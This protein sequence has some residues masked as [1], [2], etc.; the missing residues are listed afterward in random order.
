M[1]NISKLLTVVIPCYNSSKTI[2]RTLQSLL[3]Q[4]NKSFDV[5]VVD[6]FSSDFLLLKNIIDDF[7]DK[8]DI[9][10]IR[11][12][13]NRNGA[14]ARNTGIAS[15]KG[16]YICFL[17]SDDTWLPCKVS[18]VVELIS[19]G[20][21]K[22][23]T[24]FYSSLY[25]GT[26]SQSYS[27][28]RVYPKRGVLLNEPVSEYIF[29]HGGLIQ[30][31]T[32]VCSRELAKATMFNES[33][34]RHQDYDFVIRCAINAGSILF[35]PQPLTKWNVESNREVSKGESADFCD[36]W[37]NEMNDYLSD[38]ARNAYLFFTKSTRLRS[39]GHLFRCFALR[40]TIFISSS[41]YFKKVVVSRFLHKVSGFLGFSL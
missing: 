3:E 10:L 36:Y 24:L 23:D 11:H 39:S 21:I 13:Y 31:S 28:C 16:K 26:E 30:T 19:H 35:Y 15:A 8:L 7:S 37:L 29:L 34:K 20:K 27:E 22:E 18:K 33:F 25:L 40:A 41:M 9:K 32:L 12:G 6:D 2:S 1:E 17:D 14:A 4:S 5:V 38:D